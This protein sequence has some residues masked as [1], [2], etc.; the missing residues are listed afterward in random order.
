M[1]I[2]VYSNVIKQLSYKFIIKYSNHA[3]YLVSVEEYKWIRDGSKL[4]SKLFI[5]N[6]NKN[7]FQSN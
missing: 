6:Q 5:L 4:N 7:I 2:V 1:F 3:D